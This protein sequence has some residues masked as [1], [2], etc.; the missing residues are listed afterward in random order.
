MDIPQKEN[1]LEMIRADL[2]N[3]PL[4][5]NDVMYRLLTTQTSVGFSYAKGTVE[6]P[7]E[8]CLQRANLHLSLIVYFC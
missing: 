3:C 4:S 5:D 7:T 6:N 2:H 1:H 8:D